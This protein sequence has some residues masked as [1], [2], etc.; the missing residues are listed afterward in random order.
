MPESIFD[1]FWR[2]FGDAVPD[3]GTVATVLRLKMYAMDGDEIAPPAE[4][5]Q[6]GALRLSL[7][8]Y[9]DGAEVAFDF[10]ECGR[11]NDPYAPPVAAGR[12]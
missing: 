4:E 9:I 1:A 10:A 11:A 6:D 2:K 5:T 8:L 7:D 12:G 3:L